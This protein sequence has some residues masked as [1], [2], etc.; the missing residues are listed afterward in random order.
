MG[1]GSTSVAFELAQDDKNV[2]TI[3]KQEVGF[4]KGMINEL[5][6]LVNGGLHGSTGLAHTVAEGVKAV[7][8][9]SGGA[10]AEHKV[11][12]GDFAMPFGLG[13]KK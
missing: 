2:V 5:K 13:R 1:I 7:V 6:G 12:T 8:F 11:L 10:V 3:V 9:A 4:G